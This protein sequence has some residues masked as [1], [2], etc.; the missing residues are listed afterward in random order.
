MMLLMLLLLLFV[1]VVVVQPVCVCFLYDVPPCCP[2]AGK[3]TITVLGA[4]SW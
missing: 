2:A 3:E 4:G 1:V